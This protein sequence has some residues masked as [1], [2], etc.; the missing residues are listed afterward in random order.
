VKSLLTANDPGEGAAAGGTLNAMFCDQPRCHNCGQMGHFAR[1]CPQSRQQL[2]HV[3]FNTQRNDL[4]V[5][6]AQ[7]IQYEN[8]L[9]ETLRGQVALQDILLQEARAQEPARMG[10]LGWGVP[11]G[12]VAQVA[13]MGSARGPPAVGSP[14]L[15]VGG[16][17]TDARRRDGL[18]AR[19]QDDPGLAH[20]GPP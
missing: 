7:D 5:I 9:I 14:P 13:A 8:E 17:P 15:I 20:L 18:R 1:D 19:W 4:N 16:D 6:G 2:Q 11:G 3:G 10:P 12:A